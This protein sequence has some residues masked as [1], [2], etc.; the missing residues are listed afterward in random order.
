MPKTK[1][2]WTIMAYMSGD[3]NL[4]DE[5]ISALQLVNETPLDQDFT[6]RVLFDP[7]GPRLKTFTHVGKRGNG[8]P[9]INPVAPNGHDDQ[10][11]RLK[12]ENAPDFKRVIPKRE[13][14]GNHEIGAAPGGGGAPNGE[15]QFE[16]VK[17]K[18]VRDVLQAFVR[19]TI[20]HF[21]AH[22]YLLILGGH[23]SGA[24][25]DFLAS[26]RRSSALNIQDVRDVLEM[27]R[28]DF[29]EGPFA[30]QGNGYNRLDVI[31]FDSCLM[32][33]TEIAY[34]VRSVDYLVGA[35]GFEPD[36]GWP[37]GRILHN[38][39]KAAVRSR[40]APEVNSDVL[41][42]LDPANVAKMIVATYER[43]YMDYTD[44]D[45]STDLAA[46]DLGHI[47]NLETKVKALAKLLARAIEYDDVKDAIV[48]A[49]WEA[50]GYKEEQYTDLWDFC[51]RLSIRCNRVARKRATAIR[52]A[53][54]AVKDAIAKENGTRNVVLRSCYTGAAFQHSHGV[55][56]FFPWSRITDAKGTEDLLHYGRLQFV[57]RTG[58]GEFLRVYLE[59]TRRLVRSG[60]EQEIDPNDPQI[61][62]QELPFEDSRLNHRR[63]LFSGDPNS[64]IRIADTDGRYDPDVDTLYDPDVDT[65][66]DPDLG[67]LSSKRIKNTSMKNPP[68]YWLPCDSC[69]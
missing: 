10:P 36:N 22:H 66:Y 29:R 46:L 24:V 7:G 45:I 37:Y 11:E 57:K 52:R 31:G 14:N 9:P 49:H 3:N 15:R 67:T 23:G 26:N 21:P 60:P 13:K 4:A 18:R 38:L 39:N 32:S 34:E 63:G 50:Q 55:S 8:R 48:L 5:M 64:T 44:A 53:C 17:A 61:K 54:Q 56:V 27:V 58:W 40:N 33:M 59:R 68:V 28:R 2:K 41:D 43:Y 42:P 65:L 6:L 35:E 51:N 47:Q 30:G 62:A 25:G 1:K 20:I 19:D 69:D 12:L 16:R